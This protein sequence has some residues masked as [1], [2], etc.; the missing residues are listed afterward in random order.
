MTAETLPHGA[1]DPI[2]IDRAC[3]RFAGN[4]QAQARPLQFVGCDQYG[5]CPTRKTFG[6]GEHPSKVGGSGQARS[7]RE[8]CPPLG[9]NAGD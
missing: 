6:V 5:E 3:G 1:F 7:A 8:T 4:R 2:S 9:Q